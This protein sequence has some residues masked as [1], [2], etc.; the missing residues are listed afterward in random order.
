[1]SLLTTNSSPENRTPALAL[2][3]ESVRQKTAAPAFQLD[4]VRSLRMHPVLASSVTLLS[5]VLLLLYALF[6]K[7]VYETEAI[8]YEQP[9]PARLVGETLNA[10]FDSGKYD[11]FL[12]E[13]IQRMLQPDTISAA[14]TKLPRS[15]WVEYGSSQ[16][17][18]TE[19][20][21]AKLKVGRVT[22]SYQVALTLKGS[23]PKNM[24]EVLNAIASTYLDLVH[25][26]VLTE[27]DQ[28]AAL[29]AE[30]RQRVAK[31]LQRDQ[32]EQSIL[33]ANLGVAN[34]NGESDPYEGELAA[35]REQLVQARTAH[36]AA[37]AR[38]A[39]L[40]AQQEGQGSALAAAA[41]EA[42][43]SDAGLSALKSS[44]SERRAILR[45]QMLGMTSDNPLRQRDQEELTDLDRSLEEMTAKLRTSTERDLQEKLRAELQQTGDVEARIN[46]Q[47][48]QRTAAATN[49]TPKL[50]RA[51]ELNGDL[52]RLLLRQA[53]LD[54]ATQSLQFEVSSPSAARLALAAQIPTS[55]EGNRKQ[56][57]LLLSFPLSLLLGA[58]A[59]AIAR[60]CDP[61]IY[62]GVDVENA[63]G[64]LPLAVLPAHDEVSEAV[65]AEN[66]LRMA[67]GLESAYRAKGV[68][69]FLLTTAS[70]QTDIGL[71]SRMLMEK[72]RETG[73]DACRTTTADLF[74]PAYVEKEIH[75]ELPNPFGIKRFS[76]ES[77][78]S[79]GFV[80]ANLTLMQVHHSLV[81]IEASTLVDSA[82]TEYIA[83]CT[84][85]TVLIAECA[86]TTRAELVL[87]AELLRQ[88]H[89]PTIGVVIQELKMRY[90]T[91]QRPEPLVKL[92]TTELFKETPLQEQSPVLKE[93]NASASSL[94]GN[95][96]TVSAQ[97]EK[98]E[99]TRESDAQNII[100][101]A[102]GAVTLIHAK[103]EFMASG[104]QGNVQPTKNQ[105][106]FHENNPEPKTLV[107]TAEDTS[108]RDSIA[109]TS[110]S[111][112]Q[113]GNTE[114]TQATSWLVGQDDSSSASLPLKI[115]N[116]LASTDKE[117]SQC[118]LKDNNGGPNAS[119][120]IS[121]SFSFDSSLTEELSPKLHNTRPTQFLPIPRAV[122][123]PVSLIESECPLSSSFVDQSD[124]I[125]SL[126]RQSSPMV[127][128][129]V[130]DA[131]NQLTSVVHSDCVAER[132]QH[133]RH[134]SQSEITESLIV[135]K[136]QLKSDLDCPG[137]FSKVSEDLSHSHSKLERS[138]EP[139]HSE[140][141]APRLED[142][143][144]RRSNELF[145]LPAKTRWELISA[146]HPTS[147]A[148][149]DHAFRAPVSFNSRFD[150]S[151]LQKPQEPAGAAQNDSLSEQ[152]GV[153]TRQWGL[154]SR[155]Q[156]RNHFL[157]V[158][159]DAQPHGRSEDRTAV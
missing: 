116:I 33:G 20:V 18:A 50:Q 57:L 111:L 6:M 17:A 64:F 88:L 2:S 136:M 102:L 66:I 23:N 157:P 4:L 46:V 141:A 22:T 75:S 137:L 114:S 32:E 44:V 42:M 62:I 148:S 78:V 149:P 76:P 48:A 39:S 106:D 146:L 73:I 113:E 105:P 41:S 127:F 108:Y 31:A 89:V 63:L 29:L 155:F 117:I 82:E 119:S 69:T 26:Q 27:S 13:Q 122:Q 37:A 74:L 112:G 96:T 55:P 97:Q 154:L 5:F 71:L 147:L 158:F 25:K 93:A 3:S 65:I 10:S 138:E 56:L 49:S 91:N 129:N 21:L 36:D 159:K 16:H 130:Q 131:T 125:V 72:F 126:T 83:R 14:L 140:L 40:N 68:R 61:K 156:Q 51:A 124:W 94:S 11:S 45:G 128:A 101:T 15:T 150:D 58:A 90:A 47:L 120:L 151:H 107:C 70:S 142:L 12:Q 104:A 145:S 52:K 8:I 77:E 95:E 144:E 132:Q 135:V 34:P 99:V 80:K 110:V 134:S 79:Q 35:L 121:P 100:S 81:L 59:A 118:F 38:L 133:L 87:A 103:P 153:L 7:P 54:D 9:E 24:T 53:E 19:G 1:M 139:E 98:C 43:L 85:A 143:R 115:S 92:S 67:G 123:Q 86:V 30:E 152:R 84:D 28:R 60:K 109:V